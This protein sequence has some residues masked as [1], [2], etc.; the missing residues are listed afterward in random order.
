MARDGSGN[1]AIP[2]TFTPNTTIASAAVNAN[3]SDIATAMTGSLARNSEGPMTAAIVL[4][5]NGF[6]FEVDPDTGGRRSGAN[7]FAIFT[8]GTNRVVVGTATVSIAIAVNIAGALVGL[9]AATFGNTL[10]VSGSSAGFIAAEFVS[11]EAAAAAG[12]L[13]DL[14]RD[15]ASPAASDILAQTIW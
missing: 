14:F 7:E 6:N 12:P 3:F 4:H 15:S 9:S 13:I 11:T 10:T 2:N 5:T 8:E 1:Y